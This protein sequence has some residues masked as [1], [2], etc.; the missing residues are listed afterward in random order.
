[1]NKK[2]LNIRKG[3]SGK[4]IGIFKRIADHP[5]QAEVQKIRAYYQDMTATI[6]HEEM[7]RVLIS[8]DNNQPWHYFQLL[9]IADNMKPLG[10]T[11]AI[12][13]AFKLG[14]LYGRKG[15]LKGLGAK[16]ENAADQL[17]PTPTQTEYDTI[18]KKIMKPIA[19]ALDGKEGKE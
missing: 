1:M 8:D 16:F 11:A 15:T 9:K 6:T 14:V 3:R 19:E 4:K 13:F 2:K 5:S 17:T 10:A 18:R 7:A 12:G